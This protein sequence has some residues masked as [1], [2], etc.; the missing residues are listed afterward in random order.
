MA[1]RLG[2]CLPWRRGTLDLS[3]APKVWRWGGGGSPPGSFSVR[4]VSSGDAGSNT[5]PNNDA[6][7]EL[8]GGRTNSLGS[9]MGN[10]VRNK[11]V[12]VVRWPSSD[13]AQVGVRPMASFAASAAEREG[14]QATTAY[15]SSAAEKTLAGVFDELQAASMTDSGHADS[16]GSRDKDERHERAVRKLLNKFCSGP[17]AIREGR[18]LGLADKD[19]VRVAASFGRWFAQRYPASKTLASFSFSTS[20]V[21][22]PNTTHLQLLVPLFT[23]YVKVHHADLLSSSDTEGTAAGAALVAPHEWY[24][25]ARAIRRRIIYHAGPTNSGKTYRALEALKAAP[26]GVFCGPLRLLAMEVWDKLNLAGCPCTLLTGQEVKRIPS[27]RHVACTVEMVN[28]DKVV[29]VAV[30]DE[31]QL[32]GDEGRGWAWTRALLGLPAREIHLCGDPSAL[33]VVQR[34]CE[35]TGDDLQVMQYERQT[36]LAVAK[37]SLECD[38][39]NVQPGDCVVAF[40]R[41]MIFEIKNKVEEKLGPNTCAV[42][43][44]SLPPEVRR[45]QSR[46]FND[47]NSGYDVLVASDAVGMGLNLG[48]RRV[49]FHS[50]RK[51]DGEKMITAPAPHVRQIAG[52]AGRRGTTYEKGEVLTFDPSDMEGLAAALVAPVEKLTH[53]GLQPRIEQLEEFESIL[54]VRALRE[55]SEA[56]DEVKA[57]VTTKISDP[58][59]YADVL[60]AFFEAVSADSGYA[61]CS[62]RAEL[63]LARML[64]RVPRGSLQLRDY[65]Y[66][67]S[68][69]LNMREPCHLGALLSYASQMARGE[70]VMP[71]L[72]MPPQGWAPRTESDLMKL[73]LL[74]KQI[75][76]YMWLSGRFGD[77]KFP[78]REECDETASR[79]AELMNDAI[80]SSGRLRAHHRP[81]SR[82]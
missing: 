9:S 28:T 16:R 32:L 56:E 33:G 45:E 21:A 60:S 39:S 11:N 20:V 64:E 37:K 61:I 13:N 55:D 10:G 69:P 70:P 12:A 66:L 63:M 77:D 48:I 6:T 7:H 82:G 19:F 3:D 22:N 35:I 5:S 36:P 71:G 51:F 31:V 76:I 1:R 59:T 29:D 30:I 58:P 27:A 43:Y 4:G 72:S 75:G 80:K 65:F 25:V 23:Q 74:H 49:V 18:R 34:L 53:V 26:S 79:V 81:A 78:R 68:S 14:K 73:E 46:L 17:D 42:I 41:R 54:K 67:C 15:D 44:G 40:S 38:W 2:W 57:N 8:F 50:L 52:R 24:P 47:P 62:M